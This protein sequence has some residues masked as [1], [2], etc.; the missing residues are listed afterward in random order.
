MFDIC[1]IRSSWR[2]WFGCVIFVAVPVGSGSCGFDSDSP[3]WQDQLEAHSPCYEVN[4]LDG[5]NEESSDEVFALFDC[6]NYHG[7]L[8]SLVPASVTLNDPTR[9]G[10]SAAIEMA[11]GANQMSSLGLNPMGIIPIGH[12]TRPPAGATPQPRLGV[13]G[14]AAARVVFVVFAAT[15]RSCLACYA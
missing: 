2:G 9:T 6:M 11:R 3:S 14:I 1:L 10:R 5:L 13:A 8:E 12:G 4:L 7:H 15:F